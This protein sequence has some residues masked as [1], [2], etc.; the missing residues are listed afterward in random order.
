MSL[1]TANG[2]DVFLNTPPCGFI[3]RSRHD[4]VALRVRPRHVQDV[5]LVPCPQSEMQPVDVFAY[6]KIDRMAWTRIRP[7]AHRET[8]QAQA[9]Q[10]QLRLP[11]APHFIDVIAIHNN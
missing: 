3:H 4:E 10:S 9:G 6:R 5:A 7:G 8:T 1:S 11:I 2:S